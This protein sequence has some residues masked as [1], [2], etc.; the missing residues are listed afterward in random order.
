MKFSNPFQFLTQSVVNSIQR[1]MNGI[2]KEHTAFKNKL[3]KKTQ[4]YAVKQTDSVSI[5]IEKQPQFHIIKE[6]YSGLNSRLRAEFVPELDYIYGQVRMA[7][8]TLEKGDLTQK[9]YQS[10][11]KNLQENLLRRKAG[12]IGNHKEN[13]TQKK[14]SLEQTVKMKQAAHL[15]LAGQIR[16]DLKSRYTIALV[17]YSIIVLGEVLLNASSFQLIQSLLLSILISL[18]FSVAVILVG[19]GIANIITNNSIRLSKKVWY[20]LG[21][22]V[23]TTGA[24]YTLSILKSQY[25]SI[26][27]HQRVI[28]VNPMLFWFLNMVLFLSTIFIKIFLLPTKQQLEDNHNF[29]MAEKN[30]QQWEAKIAL[31]HKELSR[32]ETDKDTAIATLQKECQKKQEELNTRYQ[33]I[34]QH[35]QETQSYFQKVRSALIY[36]EQN[37]N[38]MFLESVSLYVQTLNEARIDGKQLLLENKIPPLEMTFSTYEQMPIAVVR[39]VNTTSNNTPNTALTQTATTLSS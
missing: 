16:H 1:C 8:D 29:R 31:L 6:F 39:K 36:Q 3:V 34:V 18:A 24:F 21:L 32:M 13:K 12:I 4:A 35:F 14:D 28:E 23:L 20:I 17:V 7:Q 10:Q 30:L 9:D 33:K 15:K 22:L 5:A 26:R 27:P 19:T 38:S 37:I 25:I 11:T 2:Q